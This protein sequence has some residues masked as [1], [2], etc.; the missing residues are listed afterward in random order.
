MSELPYG[1]I[2]DIQGTQSVLHPDRGIARFV[3]EHARALMAHPGLVRGL[4]L[5]PLLPFAGHLAPELLASPGLDWG[6]ATSFRRAQQSGPVA[7]YVMSPFELRPAAVETIVSPHALRADVPVIVTLYD[8]I[9]L[10]MPE[11][12]L[13]DEGWERRYRQRLALVRNA[14]LVLAISEHTRQDGIQLLGLAPEQVISIGG[15]VSSFFCPAGRSSDPMRLIRAA[16]PQI[17]RPFVLTVG[18]GDERKNIPRLITAYAGLSS[19]TRRMHQ[20]VVACSLPPDVQQSWTAHA[21]DQALGADEVVF[22]N[23]VSDTVLRALYQAA[24]LF[25]YPSLYEGYGLPVAEAAACDCPALASNTS[26]LPE[27][28]DWAEAT[29]DP[30]DPA[31]IA[32]KMAEGLGDESFRAELRRRGR[33]RAAT[34]TWTA[35]AERTVQA[36]DRLPPPRGRPAQRSRGDLR[37]ALVGPMPPTRSG[38]ADYNA[39]LVVE[40]ARRCRL[41]V[42]AAHQPVARPRPDAPC[43]SPAALGSVISPAS[44]DAIVYT[45]G[46]NQHHHQTF[47]LAR[48]YPGIVWLHDVRLGGQQVTYATDRLGLEPQQ[49]VAQ[50]LR[51][52]YGERAPAQV[53]GAYSYADSARFGLGFTA[54]W[55]RTARG[56]LVNSEYAERLVRLDQGPNGPVPP[57]WRLPFAI[58]EVQHE[59]TAVDEAPPI[60]ASFGVVDVSK[61][62]DLLVD[63]LPLI[64]SGIPVRLVFVGPIELE[65]YRGLLLGRAAEL[66]VR[67]NVH[68]TDYVAEAEYRRWLYRATCAVQLRVTSNGENS[69]ALADCLSAGLPAVTNLVGASEE[70][71][72]GAVVALDPTVSAE[73]LATVLSELLQDADRRREMREAA[74]TLAAERTF[75][76][77]A[78]RL[79]EIVE[80]LSDPGMKTARAASGTAARVSAIPAAPR[81]EPNGSSLRKRIEPNSQVY[82]MHVPK[83]AGTSLRAI[84]DQQFK[85]Q[86]ICPALVPEDLL[87]L[88][89]DDFARFRLFRGHFGLGFRHLLPREPLI[90]T[91]VRDPV[92]HTI[93]HYE[94]TRRAPTHPYHEDAARQTLEEFI[95]DD[96]HADLYANF[97]TQAVVGDF[98]PRLAVSGAPTGNADRLGWWHGRREEVRRILTDEEV[99]DL[100]KRRLGSFAFVGVVERMP[101]S[102]KVLA[103]T[104]S[105]A[106]PLEPPF[107][108]VAPSRRRREELPSAT[109]ELIAARTRLDAELYRFAR[110]LLDTRLRELTTVVPRGRAGAVVGPP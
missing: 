36:L 42:F 11:I 48:R 52:L 35:V 59:R 99:V 97:Q 73:Q 90:L 55:L 82:F 46:N 47:D 62:L 102:L 96:A 92:E 54:E 67:D 14:D 40:L 65:D 72:S 70:Y 86:E 50:K 109:L 16:L 63:A 13:R 23:F 18:G 37:L 89:P 71:P 51:E 101:E 80:S 88:S 85:P 27:I 75:G 8:L 106:L 2:L 87:A 15:G 105:W 103:A 24:R 6:T 53:V 76:R 3:A 68:F 5:N 44:Y 20:L 107:L 83:T 29:F 77:L 84:L 28:V 34:H 104:F 66:G 1:L 22:T 31:S 110:S 81:V 19:R 12:Y 4:S 43:F 79:I 49:F 108:N 58:P 21:R 39:R 93:S 56:V 26:S 94:H 78:D 9:P 64:R 91:L 10:V 30:R 74:L 32:A 57:L 61:G 45:V 100:V 38:I 95:Q 98:D 41:D 17:V 33:A 69:A 25:V 60:I 7:Y